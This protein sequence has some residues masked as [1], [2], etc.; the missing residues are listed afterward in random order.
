MRELPKVPTFSLVFYIPPNKLLRSARI[1]AAVECSRYSSIHA[2]HNRKRCGSRLLSKPRRL[3]SLRIGD[4]TTVNQRRD[5][6]QRG[7]AL[8]KHDTRNGTRAVTDLQ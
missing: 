1:T 6:R 2:F 8:R 5:L 7:A 3:H 4:V